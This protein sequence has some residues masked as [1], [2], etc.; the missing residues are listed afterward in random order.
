MDYEH[1][2][3][4]EC[5]TAAEIFH[6]LGYCVDVVDHSV[7]RKIDYSKYEIIYGMGPM[8]ER[9]FYSNENSRQIRIFYATGC[10]PIYSDVETTL[11]AR[12]F[13]KKHGRL[14]MKSIR[15]IQQS[16]HAQILLSDAVIVLGNKF[17][18]KTYTNCN[19]NGLGRYLRI[20]AFF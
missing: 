14:L 1:S 3:A 17:I 8:L 13:Y 7:N 16:Q 15:I 2:N 6:N 4:L 18:L 12:D 5:Y 10:N 11:K 20:E 9:S 19:P